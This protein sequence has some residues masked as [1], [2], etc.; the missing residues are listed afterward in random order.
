MPPEN[1]YPYVVI[2][3]IISVDVR[4]DEGPLL[5]AVV[6]VVDVGA[7]YLVIVCPRRLMICVKLL[8][9]DGALIVM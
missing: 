1:T 4:S 6:H 9:P 3:G 2:E 7:K 8:L 5:T